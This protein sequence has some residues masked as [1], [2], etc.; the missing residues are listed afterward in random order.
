[1]LAA[2]VAAGGGYWQYVVA[3]LTSDTGDAGDGDYCW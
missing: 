1:M 2:M 3:E